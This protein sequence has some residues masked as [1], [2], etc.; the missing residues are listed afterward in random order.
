MKLKTILASLIIAS[1]PL[2]AFAAD[3]VEKD[4]SQALASRLNS[5][6]T[7]QNLDDVQKNDF[8]VDG[9]KFHYVHQDSYRQRIAMF[10]EIQGSDIQMNGGIPL[11]VPR[12]NA[13]VTLA[14]GATPHCVAMWPTLNDPT[15]GMESTFRMEFTFEKVQEAAP[16]E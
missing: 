6:L 8:V 2:V 14:E 16:A 10:K 13:V 11:T 12:A 3:T 5:A 9:L 1:A 7:A 15:P 4:P